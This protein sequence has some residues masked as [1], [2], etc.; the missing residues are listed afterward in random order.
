MI[1]SIDYA[2]CWHKYAPMLHKYTASIVGARG[3]SGLETAKLLLDHPTVTLSRTYSSVEFSLSRA[4]LSDKAAAVQSFTEDQIS[5]DTSDFVF[6]ATPAETSLKLAPQ[7]L[8]RGKKV[9]DLSGAFRLKTS[10]YH[11][12]YGFTHTEKNL[13]QSAQYGLVPWKTPPVTS[14][15]VA[16]PGCYSSAVLMGILPALKAG[17][18]QNETLTVD[19]KSGT[20]GGGKN[21][22]ENLLFTEVEGDC[23]PYK[24]G[25]HQHLPEICEAAKLFANAEIEPFFSTSLLPIRR[26]IIAAIFARV[27][28]GVTLAKIDSAF[29]EAYNHYPL[30]R[31]AS[32]EKQPEL[33]SLQRVVGTPFT[34]I[35][36]KLVGDK[37]YLFSTL[38]NLV[39][40][41]AG[42]AIENL[43][44][45]LDLPVQ[46]GLAKEVHT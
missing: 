7:L 23:L 40:G 29:Q 32:V 39:K 28:S 1:F 9:I 35:S 22:K 33:M 34:H 37:L 11:K 41:A 13:L 36:Y 30:V 6:L 25:E 27:K 18:L 46:T 20:S 45:L 10:D 14:N 43:N 8:A 21:P 24:V 12:W 19:A 15:L 5:T 26:G 38:D 16:N 4:L 2:T 42:Q 31:F 17:L 44:T 3:Y